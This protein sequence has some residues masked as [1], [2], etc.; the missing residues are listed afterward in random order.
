MSGVKLQIVDIIP[1][2]ILWGILSIVSFFLIYKRQMKKS[3][4]LILYTVSL[5]VGGIIL[6]GIPS[7]VMPIQ[8]ILFII[9]MGNPILTILPM[10]I[11][12]IIL[13]ATTFVIGRQF[14]GYACPLGALQELISR[15]QFKATT[16]KRE[17]GKYV[18]SI[19]KNIRLGIRGALFFVF[20]VIAIIWSIN[21]LQLFNPFLGFPV[22]MN[23]LSFVFWVPLMFLAI[24]LV[25]SFFVYR[26]WCTL[27][28]PFGAI[29]NLTSR[30]SIYKIE[31]TEDCT[32]CGLCEQVCPT[33]EAGSDDSKG[34]C[35]L[36]NRCV[37]IC[38][39]DA[40]K[41]VK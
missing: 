6:G 8:Q 14:C 27:A 41:L 30:F 10:I 29:T 35:Y 25:A 12:L 32:D 22:F 24:T 11:I 28:C 13:I 23:P 19:P 15:V 31:R 9:T 5:I 2:F 38:L 34:E 20:F 39:Q 4:S 1:M 37:D 18:L 21:L 16:K 17:R 33:D 3:Y 40:L 36:C 7:A 26:P